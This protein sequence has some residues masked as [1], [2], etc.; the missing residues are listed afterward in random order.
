MPDATDTE[1]LFAR[2]FATRCGVSTSTLHSYVHQGLIKPLPDSGR[3]NR[4][5]GT[6]FQVMTFIDRLRG[7][8]FR[9]SLKA[10]RDDIF[11]QFTQEQLADMA[12]LD[13]DRIRRKLRAKGID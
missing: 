13:D 8:P 3:Y 1:V 5:G 9:Y 12:V 10:I 4:Y 2:D 11:P 6:Q 7:D